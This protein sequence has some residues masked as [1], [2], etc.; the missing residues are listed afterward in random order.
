MPCGLGGSEVTNHRATKTN[1]RDPRGGQWGKR[2]KSDSN[3]Y[4]RRSTS[5]ALDRDRDPRRGALTPPNNEVDDES[6]GLGERR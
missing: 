1:I 2:H 4:L 3:R 6:R 5:Q